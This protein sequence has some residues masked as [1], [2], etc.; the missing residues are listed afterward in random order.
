LNKIVNSNIDVSKLDI[1]MLVNTTVTTTFTVISNLLTYT[2]N[3]LTNE[4]NMIRLP[5]LG[6]IQK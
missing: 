6:G 2:F 5:I 3:Y 1:S 4:K